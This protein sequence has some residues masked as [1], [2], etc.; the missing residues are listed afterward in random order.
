MARRNA[1]PEGGRGKTKAA[2]RRKAHSGAGHIGWSYRSDRK[3]G[4]AAV[5][6]YLAAA[7][8]SPAALRKYRGA[9]KTKA[10]T[11]LSKRTHRKRKSGRPRESYKTKPFLVNRNAGRRRVGRYAR[12]VKSFASRSGLSGPSLMRAAGRAWRGGGARRNAVLP[13]SYNRP[14]RRGRR[15]RSRRNAVLPV[16]YNRPRRR[17]SRSRRNS[18]ILP[19]SYNSG[20]RYRNNDPVATI[21]ASL[22][23]TMDVNFWTDTVLPLSAGFIGGQF[24]GGIAYSFISKITGPST[25]IMGAVQRIG[26]RALGAVAAAGVSVL[27]PFKKK[28]RGGDIAAKV[29]AGGLVAVFAA[30]LQEILGAETYAKATGMADF[31]NLANDLTEELKGRIADSVRGEIARQEGGVNGVSAF[32]TAQDLQASQYLGPGPQ[33]GRLNSFA[34]AE[35]I[36]EAPRLSG[37]GDAPCVAD[38][39]TFSDS[40]ADAML[41]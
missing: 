29:L 9:R 13:V 7:G 38:L 21:Q 15:S 12:F 27:I 3:K 17:R 36:A 25:G 41:V 33:M 31:D 14:R 28:G 30:V 34:T 35:E 20:R 2:R 40:M 26:S 10:S 6:R 19:I 24:L 22:K 1:W 5:I 23:K 39:G 11:L 4:P 18:P 16:S 32:V 8:L 37:I